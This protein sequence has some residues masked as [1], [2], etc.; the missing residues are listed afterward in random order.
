M[1]TGSCEAKLAAEADCSGTCSGECTF[2]PPDG[3]CEGGI[4]AKCEAMGSAMV[5]CKGSC[6]GNIEPPSAK[7]DCQASAKAEAKL[8]VQCTPPRV[9]ISYQLKAGVDAMAQAQFVAALKNLEVRLPALL[10]A[11]A[12]AKAVVDAGTGLGGDGKAAVE[13]AINGAVSGEANLKAK[14]GLGC[15][16][17]QLGDVGKAIES[18][19]GRLTASVSASTKLQSA[20]LGG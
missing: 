8:N 14:I 2:T 9:A 16:L 5:D 6:E 15:A 4:R 18:A 11:I 7:A 1:C 3:N 20:L 17:T 19:S 10:A 13:G 12:Q